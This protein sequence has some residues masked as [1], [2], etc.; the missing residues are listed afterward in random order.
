MHAGREFARER[1]VRV[2]ETALSGEIGRA[3]ML[4]TLRYFDARRGVNREAVRELG[5]PTLIRALIDGMP[6]VAIWAS[7]TSLNCT[8]R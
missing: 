2:D 5:N 8:P 7:S 3:V 6:S 4:A 1:I